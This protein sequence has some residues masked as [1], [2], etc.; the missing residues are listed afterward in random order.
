[1][2]IGKHIAAALVAAAS[3]AVGGNWAAAAVPQTTP[4]DGL[5]EK[6]PTWHA[7]VGAKIVI[8]P[9][10]ELKQG[11]LVLRDG[12]ITAVGE[13][14][15]IPAGA[16][17]HR[18][19]GKTIY[20][21]LID[22]GGS[23]AGDSPAATAAGYWSDQ[24]RPEVRAAEAFKP[25][26]KGNEAWRS[27][28]VTA[29]LLAPTVGIIHGSSALVTTGDDD[30]L[31]SLVRDRVALHLKLTTERK[32]HDARYPNSPMGAVALVRQALYD[33]RWYELAWRA[34]GA[35]AKLPRPEHNEALKSLSIIVGEKLPVVIEA[36][37][38]L[39]L[40]RAVQ[41]AKEFNLPLVVR[42]SGD[43]YQL[44]DAVK[45]AGCPLVVPVDFPKPP[46]VSTPE[47]AR[48]VSVARLLHWDEAP[49][50]PTRLEAAGIRFALGS[51][52]LKEPAG[53]LPAVRRAVRRGLS[54]QAA[55]R[56]LTVTPAELWHVS[57][58]LGTLEP[59][60]LA[61]CIVTDGDLFAEKTKIVETWVDGR[62]YINGRPPACDVRG[63]W[64]AVVQRAG[65]GS[66]TLLIELAGEADKPSG[67]A[68]RGAKEAK[69]EHAAI[70]G[71][72]FSAVLSGEKLGWAGMLQLS[73]A[74]EGGSKHES[75]CD[76]WA[77]SL[78][79]ADG[80]SSRVTARRVADKTKPAATPGDAGKKVEHSAGAAQS[81]PT[82]A[83]SEEQAAD[84]KPKPPLVGPLYPFGEYGR[85]TPRP[86]QPAAVLFRDAT[87]WTCGPAGV[88]EHASVLVEHGKVSQVGTNIEP[89]A[90]ATIVDC[91][92]KHLTPGL[93]DCHSHIAT[94][95]GVNEAGQT[96]T[97]EVRVGDFIDS[98]DINIY[99]Q[100][101]GGVT[102][103]N[104]LHGSA[105]VIGGQS[106]VIKFRWGALPK[107]LKFAEAPPSIKFALGENVKQ[108]NWGDHFR[109]R[110][111]QSRLGVEQLVRD[112]FRAAAE[113]RRRWLDWRRAKNG[114]PPRTDLELEAVAEVLEGKRL[115]HCH[116]YRQDEILAL[117]RV[118][119][120]FHVRIATLQHILEG[121]KLAD[122]LARRRI[123]G[124]SFSDWWAYK[125]EVLDAI[126]YNGALM[127]EAGVLVSF[128]SDDAEL[129][130]RLNLEAAKAV[131]YGGVPESEALK[132]VTLNPARQL[133]ID[134]WVG[135]IEP[136]K[137][138]DLVLWNAPPL[139]IYSRPEQTWIEGRRYFDRVEDAAARQQFRT[140]H[141][142]LVQRVLASA[143]TMA[144]PSDEKQ[145]PWPR[146]DIFCHHDDE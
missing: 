51:H 127:R 48:N 12:V 109:S 63:R 101:A 143:E 9:G 97:A 93:I 32:F 59:G 25:D 142:K 72:Q 8:A 66:E 13:D 23:V 137:H 113:Y 105:N 111:P 132:F 74:L 84:A 115:V 87:V 2:P 46:D 114:L 29:R 129:A 42:G 103:A 16:R 78:V 144:K 96:I 106:Q 49:A 40:L 58:R 28:G 43:E 110:Y 6:K 17:V 47:K 20:P 37:D 70:D 100:L 60:K 54:S 94:D 19:T 88:I 57:D 126:P 90:G 85:S 123:G 44:I 138:A 38:N 124:S 146:E 5:R 77:G 31:R 4:P 135:S 45:Q 69:L 7:L 64:E 133:G 131:K 79:W 102:C 67:T 80:T 82:P 76:G 145:D 62:R 75:A 24:V 92:G 73:V 140:L 130:R 52:G 104:I 81:K 50:N 98:Q 89:P 26:A 141:A 91:R 34:A 53:L 71:Q 61:H 33:A 134:R 11:I 15:T 128:N 10:K 30:A 119:D 107:E 65:G 99:R 95:G 1:M 116:S 108:S 136:G 68:H 41:I 118:C 120:D 139:S 22:S 122:E 56:A 86:A 21:G 14:V 3:I 39:Y 55:L 83:E 18:L 112:E 125:Y 117:L 35:D 121:Y 27:Q 36:S